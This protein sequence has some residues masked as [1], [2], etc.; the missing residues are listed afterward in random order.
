[1]VA[2]QLRGEVFFAVM[3]SQRMR[4]AVDELKRPTSPEEESCEQSRGPADGDSYYAKEAFRFA[5][6]AVVGAS[7]SQL[8]GVC[9]R[10][11]FSE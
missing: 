1:M 5:W 2:P 6:Y 8:L 10:V 11:N 4:L 7:L 9:G 3:D